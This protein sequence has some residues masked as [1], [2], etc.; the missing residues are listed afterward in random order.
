M[1]SDTASATDSSCGALLDEKRHLQR[2]ERPRLRRRGRGRGGHGQRQHFCP[3]WARTFCTAAGVI[4]VLVVLIVS[5]LGAYIMWTTDILGDTVNDMLILRNGSTAFDSWQNPPVHPLMRI[6]I[7]NY[8]N[9]QAYMDGEDEKLLVKEV[10]PYVFREIS[11]KTD[12]KFGDNDTTIT[13]RLNNTYVFVPEESNGTLNDTVTVANMPLMTAFARMQDAGL[14]ARLALRSGMR[15]LQAQPFHSLTAHQLFWGYKD[16]LI[17]TIQTVMGP[18]NPAMRNL[19]V[20][21]LQTKQGIS[22]DVWTVYSGVGEHGLSKLGYYAAYNGEPQV[23]YY[24]GECNEIRGSDGSRFPPE[25]VRPGGTLWVYLRETCRRTLLVY[26][27]TVKVMNGIPGLRFV[28]QDPKRLAKGEEDCFCSEKDG[29]LPYALMDSSYCKN[30]APLVVSGP[31]FLKADEDVRTV[32]NG[33]NPVPEKHE[34]YLVIHERM[35]VPIAGKSRFQ[36]NVKVHA[37]GGYRYMNALEGKVI[38]IIWLE[39]DIG[40]FPH[41][42]QKILYFTAVTLDS[43]KAGLQHGLPVVAAMCALSLVLFAAVRCRKNRRLLSAAKRSGDKI[44]LK[45]TAPTTREMTRL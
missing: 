9:L 38:P 45:V 10:G 5:S 25:L 35:G 14:L 30:G 22:E 11:K 42:L 36:F 23:N 19:K 34:P 24:W 28:P 43:L 37:T 27:T 4:L 29:C 7:F 18:F 41:D 39:R 2:P 8:T 17:N 15:A 40:E 6:R 12:I 33:L 20:G 1:E 21:L 26:N 44:L 13:Y 16:K 3:Q 32:V 31:H